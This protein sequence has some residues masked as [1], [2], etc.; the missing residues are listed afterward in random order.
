M[1]E[2]EEE[3]EEEGEA[4]PC[5]PQHFL[6]WSCRTPSQTWAA[7]SGAQGS[8]PHM[9]PHILAGR[10]SPGLAAPPSMAEHPPHESLLQGPPPSQRNSSSPQEW[11]GIPCPH[12]ATAACSPPRTAPST[13]HPAAGRIACDS[14]FST[15]FHV[16][17]WHRCLPRQACI[18][19]SSLEQAGQWEAEHQLPPGSLPF[20]AARN[21]K[22]AGSWPCAV[23]TQVP[24]SPPYLLH[25]FPIKASFQSVQEKVLLPLQPN[26]I[27]FPRCGK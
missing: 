1:L 23:T 6:C 15:Q 19:P 13:P 10:I 24:A 18:H 14:A 3:E 7:V 16:Q 2:E 5:S 27:V 20:P 8:A 11:C 22:Q 9:Q 17:H 21:R 4:T 25:L 26:A 12:P